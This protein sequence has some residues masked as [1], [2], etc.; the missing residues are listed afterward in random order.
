M[1][2][3]HSVV[4]SSAEILM[5]PES[6]KRE[7]FGKVCSPFHEPAAIFFN[8]IHILPPMILISF[9]IDLGAKL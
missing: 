8:K 6:V 5:M 4:V 7:A 3:T 1:T 2:H 9:Q